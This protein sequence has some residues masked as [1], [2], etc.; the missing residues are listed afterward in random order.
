[1]YKQSSL[2]LLFIGLA[3]SLTGCFESPSWIYEGAPVVEFKNPRAGFAT[4]PTN[5]VANTI[6]ARTVRQGVGR[7]SILVQLVGPQRSTPTT[8]GYTIAATS[9]AVEG[10]NYSIV[11]T[12]GS[13]VI[14]A[15]SSST[16]IV[17]QFLAGIPAAAP[18][19]QTVSLAMTLTGSDG[20]LPSE[21]YKTFTFTILK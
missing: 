11:G 19:T 5:N 14:P 2:L 20:T 4:Q 1:M 18:A 16:Y 17:T 21:N 13:V 15:N 8:V 9:T 6:R 12:K 10:V 3:L 7:D